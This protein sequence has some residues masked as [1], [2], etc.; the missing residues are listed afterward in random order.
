MA[1]VVPTKDR[2]NFE[3]IENDFRKVCS[4]MEDMAIITASSY[5]RSSGRQ[6]SC[7]ADDLILFA[8][9]SDWH[10]AVIDYSLA[11]TSKVRNDFN[12]YFADYKIFQKNKHKKVKFYSD[13]D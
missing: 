11:Y 8:Q 6:G 1:S 10:K 3:L 7:I 5:L 12:N 9:N 2:I 4:V 13:T